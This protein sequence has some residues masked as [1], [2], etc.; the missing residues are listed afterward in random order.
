MKSITYVSAL[1]LAT[2]FISTGASANSLDTNVSVEAKIKMDRWNA[3]TSSSTPHDNREWERGTST[4]AYSTST[5]EEHRSEVANLVQR[6]L[7]IADRDHGI[8][9]DVRV[10]A[11]EQQDDEDKNSDAIKHIEARG[12]FKTFFW[13]TDYK[14]TGMLRSSIVSTQNRIDR[15]TKA[16]SS[17]TDVSVR[18]DLIA[19][20]DALKALQV[21]V[22]AFVKA[23][24]GK[25]SL[26]GWF[27][28]L[29]A[30][31]KN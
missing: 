13:G 11:K 28:K 2:L 17:T 8:G 6:L 3:T 29:F 1:A 25:F 23:N 19:Q 31:S 9:A 20:I 7:N 10:V 4:Y 26:F 14:N 27:A 18:A 21:K 5:G 12:G 16:A 15:L 30:G 22:D 24:E